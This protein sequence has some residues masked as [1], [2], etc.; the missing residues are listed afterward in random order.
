MLINTDKDTCV[1]GHYK[2]DHASYN[3][4][5]A[6]PYCIVKKCSCHL[7]IERKK[8]E[9]MDGRSIC[10]RAAEILKNDG[11]CQGSGIDSNGARD[12]IT[13]IDLACVW[14]RDAMLIVKER[15][16]TI[17]PELL[18]K[19]ND[20]DGRTRQDCIDLLILTADSFITG[21]DNDEYD[22]KGVRCP[23]A[24]GADVSELNPEG[25]G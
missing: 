1:C 23:S 5:V 4:A 15:I 6:G 24:G 10:L 25:C 9:P 21:G 20:R 14:S 22:S 12:I 17:V 13:A 8:P 16:F 11:W 3:E 18:T 19:W 7:F 2:E